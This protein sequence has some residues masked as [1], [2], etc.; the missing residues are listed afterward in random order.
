MLSLNLRAASQLLSRLQLPVD[1]LRG[2]G[3]LSSLVPLIFP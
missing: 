1:L 2:G 3:R